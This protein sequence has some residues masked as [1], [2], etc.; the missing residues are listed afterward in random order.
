MG[1]YYNCEAVAVGFEHEIVNMLRVMIRNYEA[2]NKV[3]I[4][5]D[6]DAIE[7]ADALHGM[8]L[9]LS[10]KGQNPDLEFLPEMITPDGRWDGCDENFFRIENFGAGLMAC[11][12]DIIFTRYQ[13][14]YWF[15]SLHD[16]CEGLYFFG[17]SLYEDPTDGIGYNE[18]SKVS[19]HEGE[20]GWEIHEKICERM[21]VDPDSYGEELEDGEWEEFNQEYEDNRFVVFNELFEM[22]LNPKVE[23][24]KL[25]A[26]ETGK[27]KYY[28]ANAVLYNV[29]FNFLSMNPNSTTDLNKKKF[30]ITNAAQISTHSIGAS[31]EMRSHDL[32]NDDAENLQELMDVLSNIGDQISNIASQFAEGKASLERYSDYLEQKETR[33]KELE[34]EK[35]RKKEEAMVAG[36]SEKDI[37]NMYII[38][39]NEKKFGK[40]HRSQDDF[41]ETYEEDF[42]SLSVDEMSETRNSLLAE[43]E[44]EFLCSYYAESFK[45][46]SVEDRFYLSTYNL[47]NLSE[48]TE[49]GVA[50]DWAI[51][52]SKE[53]YAP[54]EYDEVRRLM[55]VELEDTKKQ[56]DDQFNHIN[57]AFA[58]YSTAKEF[59][60]VVIHNKEEDGSDLQ[61]QY[62]NFQIVI[63]EQLVSVNLE[64]G[65]VLGMAVKVMNAF[66]WYWN[67]TVRDIWE[68]AIKNEIEDEREGAYNGSR[69]ANEAIEQI[70]SKFPATKFIASS[71][72]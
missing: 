58:K 46:R 53:W 8:L 68:A 21:G 67:V 61:E 29:G 7:D 62:S 26:E 70:R 42:V 47:F 12:F 3:K 9:E 14:Y 23:L 40:T 2:A 66:A 32:P 6:W 16:Q 59:L 30:H 22:V 63:G 27:L 34:E 71:S 64:T 51:E 31:D 38:L 52:N 49:I 55:D 33:E 57:E 72:S 50:A 19:L 39:T 1:M 43:I 24:A 5:T 56:I 18:I 13:W 45:Q 44:D 25:S 65:G 54:T 37:V 10:S 28:V 69:L 17:S 15:K 60:R 35:A 20:V 41:Y 4:S 36:K 48:E 11:K